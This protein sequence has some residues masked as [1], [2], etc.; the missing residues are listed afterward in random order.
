MTRKDY[1][2]VVRKDG[3]RWA[4]DL[5]KNGKLFYKSWQYDWHSQAGVVLEIESQNVRYFFEG[6]ADIA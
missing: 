3:R 2:A 5:Y 4:A 1:Y 6:D